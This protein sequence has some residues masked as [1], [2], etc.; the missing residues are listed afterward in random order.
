MVLQGGVEKRRVPMEAEMVTKAMM[1]GHDKEE[2]TPEMRVMAME[3][4]VKS[5][6]A[7]K[8]EREFTTGEGWRRSQHHHQERDK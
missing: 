7:A 5:M 1:V 3:P 2:M 8:G 4:M 6:A